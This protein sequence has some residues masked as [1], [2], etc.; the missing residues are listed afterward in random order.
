MG[1]VYLARH[2]RL[3]RR[4]ALKLLNREAFADPELRARF[5]REGNLVA[6]L[7]HPNIVSVY[8]RGLEGEQLWISMQYVDGIDGSSLS[9]LT[10]PPPRA[11]QIVAETAIALDYAHRMGVLHRDVKPAN[12]LL[13]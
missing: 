1:A 7:D 12:I 8:D 6:Q 11:A 3:P 4:T 13:S 10:L 5:E 2:P 9:P